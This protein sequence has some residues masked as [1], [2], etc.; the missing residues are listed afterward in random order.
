VRVVPALMAI[1]VSLAL[2]AQAVAGPPR[3]CRE[4]PHSCNLVAYEAG[5]ALKRYVLDKLRPRL[6]APTGME[7]DCRPTNH[8]A[9]GFARCQIAVLGGGLPAPCKIEALLSRSERSKF[10]I[11]W[12]EESR[13]CQV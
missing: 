11:N 4:R 9:R 3:R 8:H 13:S 7:I 10:R 2:S 12:K 1:T 5:Q 6:T